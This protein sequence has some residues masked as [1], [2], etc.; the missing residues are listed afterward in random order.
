MDSYLDQAGEIIARCRTLAEHSEEP[1]YI[2]RTFLSEPMRSAYAQVGQWMEQAGMSVRVDD[3]GNLRGSLWSCGVNEA[4]RLIIG[5]HLDT[6]P[7]AG[8]FDGPSRSDARDRNGAPA[9]RA[10]G[11][12]AD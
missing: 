6:V 11:E 7:H 3:A 12:T 2:T 9:Q 5:S 1:G 4:L 10:Q 8:A